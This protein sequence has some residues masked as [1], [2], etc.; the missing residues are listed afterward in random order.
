MLTIAAL[1]AANTS[2]AHALDWLF[3]PYVSARATYTGNI[4]QSS[5]NEEDGLVLSVTPG[6]TLQYEG[7]RR[8]QAT[9]QYNLEGVTRFGG[10]DDSDL[11]HNLYASA[12]A[13]LVEDFLFI[14]GTASISQ[15]LISLL[16]SPADAAINDSNR[17]TTG[18]YSISPYIRHRFGTFAEAE[19]RYRVYGALFGENVASD[20]LTNEFSASLTSGRRFSDLSWGFNY[21]FRDVVA[22]DGGFGDTSYT[23]E[24]GGLSLGYSLT[25]KFRLIGSTGVE[26]IAYENVNNK[27]VDSTFWNAGFNWS[28]TRRTQFELTRGE[29]FFGNT[30]NFSASHVARI[31]TFSANY[32]ED[33]NDISQVVLSNQPVYLYLC[34]N[35]F[36]A[37]A[38]E[39]PPSPECVLIG[40][41]TT[42]LPT[43]ANGLFVAK[44]LSAGVSWGV[45]KINYSIQVY[46]TRREYLLEDN[47][48]DRAQ[49]VTGTVN[50]QLDP[51]TTAYGSLQ[52]SRIE[53]PAALTGLTFDREDDLY[54]LTCGI[55][56]QF[57]RRLFGA[58]SYSLQGR[59]S[60]DSDAEY[61]ENS[62][63][64][65]VSL[66][67]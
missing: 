3:D 58:L 1:L 54:T 17:A 48:E 12:G 11:Y 4:E 26:R 15:E 67:F 36:V 31:A 18:S 55:N 34:S 43:L 27:D 21:S 56:R 8:L 53:D 20:Y 28:P 25:R 9:M 61:I 60:N 2:P 51:L 40:T 39:I 37:T 66:D 24:R 29:R 23:N 47:Q 13:E 49:G 19:A 42:P 62:L 6:F 16:G 10:S 14:D 65:S 59:D 57:S 46:D 22:K 41:G 30:W 50:Y 33:V 32:N 64:A 5:N 63:T 45:K 38:F 52:L 7:S 44:T 35:G